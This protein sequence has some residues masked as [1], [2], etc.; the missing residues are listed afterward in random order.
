LEV[1]TAIICFIAGWLTRAIEWKPVARDWSRK[2]P[3]CPT[4]YFY[5]ATVICNSE[6]WGRE[7][8]P[9]CGEIR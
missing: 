1:V 7:R 9:E 8:C 4:G 2:C 3:K 5:P 6:L